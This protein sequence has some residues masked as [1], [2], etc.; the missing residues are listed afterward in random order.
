[1]KILGAY[2][3]R[4]SKEN[5]EIRIREK[6][7]NISRRSRR[8]MLMRSARNEVP[9]LLSRGV[10]RERDF[11]RGMSSE[12]S[13]KSLHRGNSIREYF[14]VSSYH[15]HAGCPRIRAFNFDR[16]DFPANPQVISSC[17]RELNSALLPFL[18]GFTI[19]TTTFNSISVILILLIRILRWS[20]AP[21]LSCSSFW[22]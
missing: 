3:D 4:R 16:G 1:M 5:G 19:S 14:A 20:R 9:T 17:M 13:W 2:P 22:L 15:Y 12:Q 6:W 8:S 18:A 10:L 11:H 7:S 21:L